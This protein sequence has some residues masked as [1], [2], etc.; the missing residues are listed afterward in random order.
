MKM[1]DKG[2]RIE[3][4]DV[5]VGI[6]FK[7]DSLF[8]SSSTLFLQ[9]GRCGVTLWQRWD[10]KNSSQVSWIMSGFRGSRLSRL[11][12]SRDYSPLHLKATL[13]L[14]QGRRGVILWHRWSHYLFSLVTVIHH[15]G[16]DRLK[17]S[18]HIKFNKFNSRLAWHSRLV[19]WTR[20]EILGD[21]L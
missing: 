20:G 3:R 7:G 1:N 6:L 10:D 9:Q 16:L 17:T 2:S 11:G 4:E 14:Q 18:S 5:T 12:S 13:Y 15:R 21:E 8:I 19:E